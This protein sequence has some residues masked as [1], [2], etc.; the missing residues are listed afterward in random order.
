VTRPSQTR[1]FV[2]IEAQRAPVP[3]LDPAND[4]R[5]IQ[6]HG[7]AA[8]LA[9]HGGGAAQLPTRSNS[10]QASTIAARSP[11]AQLGLD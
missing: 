1:K 4:R 3:Q 9:Q 11:P 5:A 8:P 2:V 10:P 7:A 6:G